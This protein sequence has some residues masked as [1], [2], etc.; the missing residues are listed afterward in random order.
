MI[1]TPFIYSF[2]FHCSELNLC[3]S[4]HNAIVFEHTTKLDSHCRYS[5]YHPNGHNTFKLRKLGENREQSLYFMYLAKRTKEF[6]ICY[7]SIYKSMAAIWLAFRW[8]FVGNLDP[9]NGRKFPFFHTSDW[10]KNPKW[11]VKKMQIFC[12]CKDL[13]YRLAK[14]QFFKE[15]RNL[16]FIVKL[17]MELIFQIFFHFCFDF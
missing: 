14:K 4:D 11:S 6:W 13:N 7:A 17:F 15:K 9:C 16:R 5:F 10:R 1:F 3:A 12:H 2:I 8:E